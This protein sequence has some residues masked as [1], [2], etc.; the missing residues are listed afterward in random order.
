MPRLTFS[1]VAAVLV[2]A[3]LGV[4]THAQQTSAPPFATTKV[5]GMWGH[6]T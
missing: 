2:A 3:C 4:V 1:L 5:D 6:G